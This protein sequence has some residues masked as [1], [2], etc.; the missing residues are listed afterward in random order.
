[1]P[2]R[3]APGSDEQA[4]DQIR[5][6]LKDAE[7]PAGLPDEPADPDIGPDRERYFRTNFSRMKLDWSPDEKAQMQ[8]L[9][10]FA[11]G[12]LREKFPEIYDLLDDELYPAVREPQLHPDTQQPLRDLAGN[13]MWKRDEHNRIIERYDRLGDAEARQILYKIG[14]QLIAWRQRRDMLHG[15]AMFAKGLWEEVFS[16]G[17]ISARGGRLTVDDKTQAG[18]LASMDERYFS[19]FK[20]MISRRADSLVYSMERIEEML[21]KTLRS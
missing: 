17:Y 20:S 1:M 4:A 15:E 5:R 10:G 3:H 13:V 6:V 12:A 2:P 14:T 16:N 18:R 11:D 8:R 7:G 19:I 21:M 9:L